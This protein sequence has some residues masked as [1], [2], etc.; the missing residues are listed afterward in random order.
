MEWDIFICHASEDKDRFVDPLA[1]RL[2]HHGFK[3]WYDKFCLRVGDSVRRSIEKGLINSKYGLVVLSR[4]FFSKEWPQREL[5]SLLSIEAYNKSRILPIWFEIGHD[6]ICNFSPLLAD[7]FALNASD[8]LD[9]IVSSI[10][11]RVKI[12]RFILYN[13]FA[14]RI[15]CFHSNNKYSRKF[16]LQRSIFNL[17]KLACFHNEMY[18]AEC[19]FDI[20]EKPNEADEFYG[21]RFSSLIAKYDIPSDTYLDFDGYL[22]YSDLVYISSMIKKWGSG[23]LGPNGSYEL[24][25]VLDEYFDLDCMFILFDLP[26][27]KISGEQRRKLEELIIYYGS[28]HVEEKFDMDRAYSMVIEKYYSQK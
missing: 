28:R 27:F 16:I 26:N 21:R 7:K 3:V 23:R 9:S 10:E 2:R 18:Q 14:E 4:H 6:E 20:L 19:P 5:D 1:K 11:D 12:D 24:F 25:W 13:E 8:G 17:N 15:K 22:K